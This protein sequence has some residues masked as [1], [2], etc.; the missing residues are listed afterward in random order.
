MWLP[1][2]TV[3][4]DTSHGRK[5][6]GCPTLPLLH[7]DSVG[8]LNSRFH[9]T[10]SAVLIDD[11]GYIYHTS[12]CWCVCVG[13]GVL[14]CCVRV[15]RVFAR[16]FTTVWVCVC[17][18]VCVCWLVFW[19]CARTPCARARSRVLVLPDA[20]CTTV[21]TACPS[22]LLDAACLTAGHLVLNEQSCTTERR[23]LKLRGEQVT[24]ALF[25]CPSP[26]ST[27]APL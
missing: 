6:R 13:V 1:Q 21:N 12:V 23:W 10:P 14:A 5:V 22:S 17:V 19:C 25:T 20:S 24:R 18:C 8:G 3:T 9:F 7:A 16:S 4:G 2:R 27:S 11:C 15:V 26:L